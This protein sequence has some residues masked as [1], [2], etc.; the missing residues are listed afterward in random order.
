MLSDSYV[1][2]NDGIRTVHKRP[3]EAFFARYP[4]AT[5]KFWYQFMAAGR[6]DIVPCDDA[7]AFGRMLE[8][9]FKTKP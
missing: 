7:A 9:N 4:P 1:T 6:R 8:S 3:R 5:D 2:Q